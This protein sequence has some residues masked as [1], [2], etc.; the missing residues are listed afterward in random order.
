MRTFRLL[1]LSWLLLLS[2]AMAHARQ[3]PRTTVGLN[4]VIATVEKPFQLDR[5]GFPPLS[6]VQADF[7]Q[8]TTIAAKKR[9]FRADGEMLLQIA[10]STTA[11]KFR[12][13]YFRPMRQEVVCDGKTFW[14][15]L[16]EN[17]QVLQSD[18]SE[19]FDPDRFSGPRSR[20]VNFLQGL[21]RISKDFS[22]AFG[23]P[24]ND[25]VGNYILEL[26]PRRAS[27]FIEKLSITVNRES[28]QATI[29]GLPP[30]VIPSA[31]PEPTHL[32]PILSTTVIDHDG[33]STTMEFSNI[34]E[35]GSLSE[36]L[37][38]FVPPLDVQV[39]RP[40]SGR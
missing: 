39:V 12:F 23:Q 1:T 18:V 38:E 31:R 32:F 2:T 13:E 3:L 5:D 4:D 34:R 28:L 36:M 27:A 26:T 14:V 29:G 25:P 33:N 10:T 37:F 16:P 7:F 19:F 20:A 22:I 21:G 15:Y 11:L 17:R 9:E 8:R 24:M 35:N 30:S 6:T 40:P